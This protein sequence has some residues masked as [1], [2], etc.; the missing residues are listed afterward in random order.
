M[1]DA[2]RVLIEVATRVSMHEAVDSISSTSVVGMPETRP[3][4]S[5]SV[6]IRTF[7]LGQRDIRIGLRRGAVGVPAPSRT[8]L[9]S[10]V[11]CV[12][13][14]T[15]H[16]EWPEVVSLGSAG[17]TAVARRPCAKTRYPAGVR[18][19]AAAL[20]PRKR[21]WRCSRPGIPREPARTAPIVSG[22]SEG[23]RAKG[24]TQ[25]FPA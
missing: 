10:A 4:R 21:I 9:E 12:E 6:D 5:G 1:H 13:G 22:R 2:Q 25:P 23:R 3:V 20:G 11:Q 24:L 17:C 18:S 19:G 8:A 7:G 14:L 15:D 16:L